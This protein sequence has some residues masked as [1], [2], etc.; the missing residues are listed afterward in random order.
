MRWDK[1]TEKLM[2]M[3][4]GVWEKHASP[5]SFWTRMATTPFLFIALWSYVWIGWWALAPLGVLSLWLWMNP[6]I[7]PKPKS[8]DNWA[9][10][11]VMGER[12][13]INRKAVPIPTHHERAGQ[14]LVALAGVFMVLAIYGFIVQNFWIAFLAF[15]TSILMKIWFVDRMAWLYDDMREQHAEYAAWLYTKNDA[16]LE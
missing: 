1:F 3:D 16:G 15:H 10:K 14:I 12:V 5:W 9:S 2:S 6:R 7:F 11:G 8:T 4:E 13:F